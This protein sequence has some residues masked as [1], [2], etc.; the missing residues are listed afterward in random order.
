MHR[1][2]ADFRFGHTEIRCAEP[3]A[4]GAG[5]ALR[6]WRQCAEFDALG[7]SAT[8][9]KPRARSAFGECVGGRVPLLQS[10]SSAV[11]NRHNS[12]NI[13]HTS[14]INNR[15]TW[16]L[17]VFPSVLPIP[18]RRRRNQHSKVQAG[19]KSDVLHGQSPART[20]GQEPP[21]CPRKR[22]PRRGRAGLGMPRAAQNLRTTGVPTH[23][24]RAANENCHIVA[25]GRS[26]S[27]RAQASAPS[28]ILRGSSQGS[29][30]R[31]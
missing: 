4:R 30:L 16:I 11:E 9:L 10:R 21:C 6:L 3:A 31:H 24:L 20:H 8:G 25:T 22:S 17:N 26:S 29:K 28:A 5:Q 7:A 18:A 14:Y 13:I 15:L 2:H 1:P 12:K 19:S 27:P 23:L